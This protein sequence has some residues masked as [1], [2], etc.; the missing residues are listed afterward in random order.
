MSTWKLGRNILCLNETA[1]IYE[2]VNKDNYNPIDFFF[3]KKKKHT[4]LYLLQA[5]YDLKWSLCAMQCKLGFI[6]TTWTSVGCFWHAE[7][8][9]TCFIVLWMVSVMYWSNGE[10]C[11]QM[12]QNT[13]GTVITSPSSL[14][15]VSIFALLLDKQMYYRAHKEILFSLLYICVCY[16]KN[17]RHSIVLLEGNWS[18]PCNVEQ[19]IFSNPY[20]GSSAHLW[21]KILKCLP[22]VWQGNNCTE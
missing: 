13:L 7:L 8:S 11:G 4:F 22:L 14:A 2:I 10:I 16:C 12:R 9:G 18:A 21:G 20:L 6:G 17:G 1:Y 19:S 3:F 5:L 15:T